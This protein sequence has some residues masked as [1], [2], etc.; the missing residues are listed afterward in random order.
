[1]RIYVL[2]VW[3]PESV[4]LDYIQDPGIFPSYFYLPL[5]QSI[6]SAKYWPIDEEREDKV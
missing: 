6:G 5:P 1:M 2:D 4:G 3:L